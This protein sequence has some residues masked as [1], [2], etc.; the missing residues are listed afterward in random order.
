M[1]RTV[2]LSKFG[3]PEVLEVRSGPP[4]VMTPGGV[5]VQVAAAGVNFADLM[6][7]MGLYPEAPPLPFVPGYEVAGT[8]TEISEGAA[9][10]RP[11][12]AVGARV[13][14]VTRFGGY[15]DEVVVPGPKVFALPDDFSFIEGA[16]FP[17]NYLTAW[18][19]LCGMARVRTGDRVVVHGAAGGVGAAAIQIARAAGARVLGTCGGKIKAAAVKR[20]GAEAVDNRAEDEETAIRRWAPQGVDVVLEPRGGRALRRSL[21]HLRPT[22]RA[23]T[24]GASDV[25][26]GTV[27]RRVRAGLRLLPFFAVHPLALVRRNQGVFGL[28]LLALWNEDEVLAE[29]VADLLRGAASGVYRPRLDITVPL[30]EAAAAHRRLHERKNIGKVVLTTE[31]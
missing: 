31:L 18:M 2:T 13:A 12:L 8:V 20:W 25:V 4:P 1:V 27:R 9:R 11:D 15:A 7:R 5:R 16:A 17:V 6:M 3:P 23:V 22:G 19:A 14:A 30:T 10:R 26:Q 28:N 29:A 24:F 21:R